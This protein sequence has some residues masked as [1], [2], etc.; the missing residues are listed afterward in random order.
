MARP[1]LRNSSYYGGYT[2]NTCDIFSDCN[3]SPFVKQLH[4]KNPDTL[5]AETK[6]NTGF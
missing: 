3:V 4:I 1:N 5:N 6:N 2:A